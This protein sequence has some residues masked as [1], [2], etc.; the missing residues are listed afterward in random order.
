MVKGNYEEAAEQFRALTEMN[1]NVKDYWINLGDCLLQMQKFEEAMVPYEKALELD[2]TDIKLMEVL[3]DIYQ[4]QGHSEKAEAL[5][6][7]MEEL[8]GQ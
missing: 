2:P 3:L 1:P 5:S 6:A 8:S 7:R 4:T